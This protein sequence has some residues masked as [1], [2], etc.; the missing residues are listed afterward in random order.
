MA[1]KW[2]GLGLVVVL[3]SFVGHSD[4]VVDPAEGTKFNSNVDFFNWRYSNTLA[5]LIM[6]GLKHKSTYIL[7]FRPLYAHICHNFWCWTCGLF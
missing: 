6:H 1:R 3:L 5:P 2:R 4:A 7:D